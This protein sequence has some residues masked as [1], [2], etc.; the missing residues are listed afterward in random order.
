[1]G[2]GESGLMFSQTVR[3]SLVERKKEKPNTLGKRW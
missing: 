1:M 3:F 2:L